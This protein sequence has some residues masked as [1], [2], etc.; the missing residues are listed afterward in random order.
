LTRNTDQQNELTQFIVLKC[1]DYESTVKRLDIEKKLEAWIY[2]VGR[3]EYLVMKK[4]TIFDIPKD[5]ADVVYSDKLEE[6]KPFLTDMDRLWIRAYVE[7]N[8]KYSEIQKKKKIHQETASE[9]IKS[10]I[11]KCKT[12]K[13]ILY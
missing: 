13:H 4:R 2:T 7:C 1:Y 8:G 12:L 10:I 6:L 9:R 3:N 11:E 5:I